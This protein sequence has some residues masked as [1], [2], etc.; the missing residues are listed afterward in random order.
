MPPLYNH[1]QVFFLWMTTGGSTQL[2]G[3]VINSGGLAFIVGQKYD[4]ICG[5]WGGC[6]GGVVTFGGVSH[7][8]CPT[9]KQ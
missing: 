2:G 7:S 6:A 5:V 1:V 8:K 9:F 3:H 4:V